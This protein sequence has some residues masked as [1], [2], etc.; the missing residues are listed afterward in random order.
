MASL[1]PPASSCWFS[2]ESGSEDSAQVATQ[3]SSRP[4]LVGD[5]R[6]AKQ[7]YLAPP[8]VELAKKSPP[9]LGL[10]T[11]GP[12]CSGLRERDAHVSLPE[13]SLEKEDWKWVFLF[14]TSAPQQD[15]PIGLRCPP[16]PPFK[17]N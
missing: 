12:F 13:S 4:V 15:F 5:P 2:R 17:G 10:S 3:V 9:I 8:L 7:N 16:F 1:W 11:G 6:S 14:V